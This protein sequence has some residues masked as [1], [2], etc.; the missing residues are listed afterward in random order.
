MHHP[1]D[2]R[3]HAAGRRRRRCAR[4]TSS[5]DDGVVAKHVA[6][7]QQPVGGEERA[8]RRGARAAGGAVDLAVREDRHVPLVLGGA[9]ASWMIV[10]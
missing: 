10:P 5:R 8:P 9:G 3:D 4:G 6:L 2:L 1:L 7:S